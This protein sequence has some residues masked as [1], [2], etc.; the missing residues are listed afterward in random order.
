[1][2]KR[3]VLWDAEGHDWELKQTPEQIAA[4]ILNRV[5][6]GSIVVLHDA[7]QLICPPPHT[8]EALRI[9]CTRILQEKKLP[10]V[11]LEFPDWPAWRCV[12]FALWEKWETLFARINQIERISAHN[13]IR[14][15]KSVYSGPDLYSSEGRL[16]AKTGDQVGEIHFDNGRVQDLDE[17]VQRSALRVL[18]KAKAAFP[19]FALYVAESPH[20]QDIKV[21]YGLTM[22]HRGARGM[23][24]HVQDVPIKGAHRGAHLL[25]IIIMWIYNPARKNKGETK[26]VWISRQELLDKWLPKTS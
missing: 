11:A 10:L 9:I 4:R 24:F 2:G 7:G 17:D 8:A 15:S 5:S 6:A 21:F 26:M 3:A 16:L 23:G 22:I 20:Y 18:N 13:F 14:L 12:I 25:H 1:W 19:E